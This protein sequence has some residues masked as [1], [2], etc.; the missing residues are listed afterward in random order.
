MGLWVSKEDFLSSHRGD[1][2][3]AAR[4]PIKIG[5]ALEVELV[6]GLREK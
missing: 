4:P 5:R 2:G 1:A 3:A 6:G